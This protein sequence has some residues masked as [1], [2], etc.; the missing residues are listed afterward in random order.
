MARIKE[1]ALGRPHQMAVCRFARRELRRRPGGLIL[2]DGVG[3][4]KTYEA[5]GTVASYL[6]QLQ[7][8]KERKRQR[9]FRV[10]VVVPP[11]LVSKWADELLLPD[12]FPRY[13]RSWRSYSHR[14]V[15]ETFS[16]IAVLRRHKDLEDRPGR[17]RYGHVVLPRG[18]YVVN[19]N[20]LYREGKKVTQ[21]H[22]T[23]WD[24][25]I[26]DEAHHVGSDLLHL[27]PHTLLA[28]KNTKTLLL[29]ATPFQLSPQDMKGLLAAT[30][31]GY[32][33]PKSWKTALQEANDL[34]FSEEFRSYRSAILSYFR[35]GSRED[36]LAAAK[37]RSPVSEL[38]RPRVIRNQKTENRRYHFVDQYGEASSLRRSPFQLDRPS[39]SREL[40]KEGLIKL[41]T[42]DAQAY[43][44]VR[45]RILEAR[46]RGSRTFIA[47]AL[48]QLLSTY[49]QFR[50][51]QA[52]RVAGVRLPTED[53][54][55]TKATSLLVADLVRKEMRGSPQRGWVGKIL[56]FT[57]YVGS[58]RAAELP[59]DEKAHGTASTLKRVLMET[60]TQRY[61]RSPKKIR[62]RIS[63]RLVEVL[64]GC[65]TSLTMPE[66]VALRRIIQRF[67]GSPLANALLSNQDNLKMEIR[68]LKK[69]LRFIPPQENEDD[70]DEKA[71][72]HRRRLREDRER[73][74]RQLMDRYST[75]D[76]VARYDG[77]TPQDERDRHLHGF[78]S[79][80][81]PLVLIASSVGQ[82]GID[83][84]R[85]CRHVIHYDLEWNP[86]KLEQREGRVDR[87][88]RLAGGPVNVY[89]L[90][91]RHT[92][93]ERIMHAMVN[94]FR[95]HHVL[96]A[97]RTKLEGVPGSA[98]E[99]YAEPNRM[100]Q[101]ALDLRPRQA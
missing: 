25:I 53:H 2:A 42:R 78:N 50:N 90:L 24:A 26:V 80:F 100:R 57:T 46:S 62:R 20:L 64:D 73:L 14:A 95:W 75:R 31:G 11:A 51:S 15:F 81:A 43:I 27:P 17:L 23:P 55:K 3:L 91:C 48:R 66:R 7:H 22:K 38:L 5:L 44:E 59:K 45:D 21:I 10:L 85:Y 4:G 76:L 87:Q 28:R 70:T 32:G 79:P 99:A 71:S 94:R 65:G 13:L 40:Q 58:D 60:L 34:Y 18:L 33:Q 72:E 97:N 39:L 101:I 67:A 89:F 63:G 74:L 19:S 8:G 69:L 47:G 92:Y 68:E 37:L 41:E 36:A 9:P 88:G 96:L 86:A 61:H 77:A 49:V 82:E 52:G 54:P 29:T 6:A 35:N 30:F 16:D 98:E 83:L 56:I 1:I 12:R 93:D 84:Q